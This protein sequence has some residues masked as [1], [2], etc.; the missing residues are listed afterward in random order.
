VETQTA[1]IVLMA[2]TAVEAVVWLAGLQFLLLSFR[3]GQSV[4]DDLHGG[5]DG[6]EASAGRILAGSAEVDGEARALVARTAGLLAKGALFPQVPVKVLEQTEDHVRFER[7]GPAVGG[8]FAGG[9]ARLGQIG[10]TPLGQG[11]TRVEWAVELTGMRWLLW[12]GGVFLAVGL[13]ALVTMC[14]VV[15]TYLVSSPEP[16]VR[17]QTLQ[18]IQVG[19]FLWPPFLFGALYRRGRREVAARFDA[20]AHNLPYLGE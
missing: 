10:F 13:I 7:V 20:M 14:W 12:L 1:T 8:Q 3:K 16:A 2:I 5:F 11:R 6:G 15:Y 19:H 17:W 4:K 18:M 9:W